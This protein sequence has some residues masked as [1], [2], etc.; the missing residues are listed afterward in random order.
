[1]SAKSPV[2]THILDLGTGRPAAG[3]AVTL[4]KVLGGQ[5]TR[6]A[7]G[8]TDDD[9]R[10][11]NWFDAPLDAG[12]YRL[13]FATGSWYQARG[14]DTFFPEVSLDFHVADTNAHY[15]VPLLLNQWGYST[16]RGS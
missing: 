1:M 16:Y 11:M 13:T 3:V 7:E 8:T 4:N 9:G 2:T 6:I 15:H 10:I 5:A 14:L 12:H